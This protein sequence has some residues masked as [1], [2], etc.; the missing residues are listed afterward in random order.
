MFWLSKCQQFVQEI[1]N[2]PKQFSYIYLWMT[3]YI[4]CALLFL[5]IKHS[6]GVWKYFFY[7]YAK[8]PEQSNGISALLWVIQFQIKRI[9]GTSG[10]FCHGISG[11]SVSNIRSLSPLLTSSVEPRVFGVSHNCLECLSYIEDKLLTEAP[12]KNFRNYL[13]SRDRK[14]ELLFL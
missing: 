12:F 4:S 1:S 9:V 13:N 10:L 11:Y 7:K 5:I 6:F 2:T 14:Q 3:I 8:L